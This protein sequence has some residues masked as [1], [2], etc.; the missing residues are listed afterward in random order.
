MLA[1]FILYT[2]SV[3]LFTHVHVVCGIPIVLSHFYDF[4]EDDTSEVGILKILVNCFSASDIKGAQ[5]PEIVASTTNQT[6]IP[7]QEH[8][9]SSPDQLLFYEIVSHFGEVVLPLLLFLVVPIIVFGQTNV[10]DSIQCCIVRSFLKSYSLRGPPS[11][12][13]S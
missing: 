12:L 13:L 2:T 9:H 8:H 11:F 10:A 3:T 4:W 6:N 7:L 5:Y 1:I